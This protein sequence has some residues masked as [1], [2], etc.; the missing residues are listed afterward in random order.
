MM[1][2]IV[3]FGFALVEFSYRALLRPR[4]GRLI[5]SSPL[6]GLK[7]SRELLATG[8]YSGGKLSFIESYNVSLINN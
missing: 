5:V 4:T 3:G 8:G 6:G 2:N 7:T 1:S